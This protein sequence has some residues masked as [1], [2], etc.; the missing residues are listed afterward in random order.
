MRNEI[1]NI[2]E[3]LFFIFFLESMYK[4]GNTPQTN[5]DLRGIIQHSFIHMYRK[6]VLHLKL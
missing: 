5:K 3:Q 6:G 1:S 4:T 2:Y